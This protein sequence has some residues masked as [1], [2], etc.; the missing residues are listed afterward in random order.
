MPVL[1][2]RL[3]IVGM[4][5]IGGSIGLAARKR[6]LAGEIV[7]YSR[8]ESS[9]QGALTAGAVDQVSDDLLAV[10]RGADLV[11]VATPVGTIADLLEAIAPAL[12]IGCTVTDAGSVKAQICRDGARFLPACFIGGHPM[13]GSEKS[14]VLAATADLFVDRSYILTPQ[15]ADEEL[16]ERL[17]EFVRSLGARPLIASPDEH[18]RLVALTSHL[19]HLWASALALG[20]SRSADEA[21]E[22]A[23][24][25]G[26][27]LRDSTRIAGSS[28]EL[29]KDIFLT[30]QAQVLAACTR[31]EQAL[32]DL[33]RALQEDDIPALLE[34]LGQAKHFRD[35]LATAT[36]GSQMTCPGVRVAIDGPAGAGK[37]SVARDVAHELGYTIIDTGAMYRAVAYFAKGKSLAPGLNDEEIGQLA[38]QLS[39]EFRT[40]EGERH[41]FV[42]GQD[43][44]PVVRLPEVGRLSSPVSAIPAVRHNLVIAQRQMAAGGGIVMEGR[45]IGT[46]VL[47]DAEVKIFLTASPQERARRRYRQLR[48]MGIELTYEDILHE[49]NVRDQRDSSRAVAPLRRADDAVE[50]L[51][52]DLTEAQV[53]AKIVAIVRERQHA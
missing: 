44:E 16:L 50:I 17:L 2:E 5:L 32:A 36:G 35:D 6:H 21:R 24:F 11:Y 48:D 7:G 26:G 53:V 27:G 33:R 20:L 46:V 45:D 41:L 14:G 37:S 47:P 19:P 49:Q 39:Y 22:L 3:A 23:G 30:N 51:S 1:Y 10:V 38:A 12:R 43:V 18:D 52:D 15:D 9:R 29:W 8:S 4:G 28:P 40:V 31:A 42:D 25:A 34:L 13:A